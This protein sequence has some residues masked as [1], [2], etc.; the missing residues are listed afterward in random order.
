MTGALDDVLSDGTGGS[1]NTM[2]G[3]LAPIFF[4]TGPLI[5]KRLI[6]MALEADLTANTAL[7]VFTSADGAAFVEQS[8]SGGL[9]GVAGVVETERVDLEGDM[10]RLLLRFTDASVDIP[11]ILG[12]QM[13]AYD[14]GRR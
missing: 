1:A 12:F 4:E 2:T 7:K 10:K 5:E 6:T 8:A 13:A 11:I 9:S 14:M 3:T